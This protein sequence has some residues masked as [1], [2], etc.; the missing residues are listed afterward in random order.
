MHTIKAEYIYN[1]L[2]QYMTEKNELK[3]TVQI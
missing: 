1:L 2:F 3:E